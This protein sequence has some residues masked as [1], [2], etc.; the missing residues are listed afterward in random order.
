[1]SFKRGD[2]IGHIYSPKFYIYVVTEER[3]EEYI[4][5]EFGSNYKL[6]KEKNIIENFYKKIGE[7]TEKNLLGE[8]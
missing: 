7:I 5:K 4:I 2:I 6:D 3:E 1:M 8:M